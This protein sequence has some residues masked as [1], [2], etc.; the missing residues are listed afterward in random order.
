MGTVTNLYIDQGATYNA[1]VQVFD[2]DDVVFNLTGYTANSQIRKNYATNT[3][4]ATFTANV[5]SPSN[6]TISLALTASQTANLKY[7]RYVYDVEIYKDDTVLRPIEGIVV[8][9]PQVTR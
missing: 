8:V 2:D 9:Y 6:G 7:G 3:V 4:A 1:I 5:L